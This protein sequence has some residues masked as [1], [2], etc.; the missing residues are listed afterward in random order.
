MLVSI[1]VPMYNSEKYISRCLESLIKQ[2]YRN[3]E[4]IVV[5]DGSNDNSINIVSSLKDKRIRLYKK[6]NSG[7]SLT[8][9]Y[10]IEKS[11]GDL[12]LFVDS[13]DYIDI[14]MIDK[15]VKKVRNKDE[16]FVICNNTEIYTDK[17]E[18]REI[19]EEENIDLNKE[20]LIRAIASGR[21]GLVCSKLVS[22][23]VIIDNNIRFDSNLKVGE[24]QLFFIEVAQYCSDFEYINESLYFY[25]RRNENSATISYQEN[26]IDNFK[27]LQ[28]KIENIFFENNMN[29]K[30]DATLL[31]NKIIS[32]FNHCM[33]NEIRGRKK[34]GVKRT[35][36][37]L[38]KILN[39]VEGLIEFKFISKQSFIYERIN[40]CIRKNS[41]FSSLE[42]F[43]IGELIA[44]KVGRDS[45]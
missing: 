18:V 15:L 28:E 17:E 25:D 20:Y 21:A 43:V 16:A 1:I 2:T 3:I 19:F 23:K 24:D 42:L 13:D 26:L 45:I 12:L 41:K 7:V 34:I 40:S 44:L 14:N 39:K 30:E 9:N 37:N 4:I 11:N 38:K 29:S 5:D 36:Q 22:R 27:Y 31:N 6:E 35:L 33:F 32:W 10:G 8:R